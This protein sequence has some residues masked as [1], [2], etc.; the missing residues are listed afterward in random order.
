MNPQDARPGGAAAPATALKDAAIALSRAS[1][2]ARYGMTPPPDYAAIDGLLGQ[3]LD[4]L[5]ETKKI[6]LIRSLGQRTARAQAQL[7]RFY[8]GESVGDVMQL[9]AEIASIRSGLQLLRLGADRQQT[10]ASRSAPA[11]SAA[12]L[13]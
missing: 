7:H 8:C 6:E 10:L 9:A 4:H 12:P 11:E 5:L 3:A 1:D 2:H 13:Q